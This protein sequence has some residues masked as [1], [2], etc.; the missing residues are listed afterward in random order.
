MDEPEATPRTRDTFESRSTT[1]SPI[2]TKKKRRKVMLQNRE[3][4]QRLIAPL[5]GT[6]MISS[7]SS[8]QHMLVSS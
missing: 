8:C 5:T 3:A 7:L 2:S 4:L 1:T 6:F